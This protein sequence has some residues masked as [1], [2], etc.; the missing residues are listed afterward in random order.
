MWALLLSL[1][2]G[3]PPIADLWPCTPGHGITY[4]VERGGQDTQIRITETVRGPKAGGL[5]VLDRVVHRP[6]GSKTKEAF[7]LEVLPDRILYA[8]FL[9]TPT[10]FRPPLVKAPL[11][12]RSAWTFHRVRYV[13]QEVGTTFDTPAGTFANCVRVSEADMKGDEHH[14][15]TVYAPKVGPIV[16]VTKGT[17]MVAERVFLAPPAKVKSPEK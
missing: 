2:V 13:V 7:L 11:H 16:K 9:E 3:A 12:R 14:G 10:A 1:V 15:Y 17:K 8:G 6:N 4:R 5:C